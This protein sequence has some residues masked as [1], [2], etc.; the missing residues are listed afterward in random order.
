M[1]FS[2]KEIFNLEVKTEKL[3]GSVE[4]DPSVVII[5]VNY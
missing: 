3:V 4:T 5:V 1:S 2:E